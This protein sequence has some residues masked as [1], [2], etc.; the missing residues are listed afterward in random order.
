ACAF[1]FK[2]G[3]VDLK[4]RYI[5]TEKFTAEDKAGKALFGP[6]RNPYF[7]DES[8]KGLSRGTAN[9]NIL[10][11]HGKLLALKEDSQPVAMDPRTLETLGNYDFGG[12]LSSPT[13][14]AHPKIDPKTGEM[15][16]FGYAAKGLTTRDVAY[17]VFDRHGKLT[18]EVW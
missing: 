15:I 12:Q 5:R 18:R 14:T 17:Y 3:K 4:T 9:T 8:V 7:D 1:S 10:V 16:T 11:H 6:Y 13:F 2:N